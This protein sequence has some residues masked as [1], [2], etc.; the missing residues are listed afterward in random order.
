MAK[1]GLHVLELLNGHALRTCRFSRVK[2]KC[3]GCGTN[4]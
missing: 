2:T 3:L 4:I 1:A